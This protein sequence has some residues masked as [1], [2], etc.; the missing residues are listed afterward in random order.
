MLFTP[1]LPKPYCTLAES[2]LWS[3]TPSLTLPLIHNSL[4]HSLN[5][6]SAHSPTHFPCLSVCP[7]PR[8]VAWACTRLRFK[9]PQLMA[10]V[11]Q[12]GRCEMQHMQCRTDRWRVAWLPKLG[13]LHVCN[14][15]EQ[16]HKQPS[17][18]RQM[19][20]WCAGCCTRA[21]S[22]EMMQ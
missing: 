13:L 8:Q 22:A 16:P 2:Q 7:P 1:S 3:L 20:V 17:P 4:T 19:H 11:M 18:A 6:Y 15:L 14:V 21:A 5:T 10:D 9:D 12:H